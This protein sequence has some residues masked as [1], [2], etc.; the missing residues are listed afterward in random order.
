[1]PSAGR[2][3][4][5]W[6]GINLA[7][8]A[9]SDPTAAQFL[10]TFFNSGPGQ[11]FLDFFLR[12]RRIHHASPYGNRPVAKPDRT[13]LARGLFL[14]GFEVAQQVAFVGIIEVLFLMAPF[15]VAMVPVVV[16]IWQTP[17]VPAVD[18]QEL[19]LVPVG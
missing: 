3:L 15:A 4:T 6:V 9:S 16:R 10:V 14:V 5:S 11:A 8:A 13:P 19:G 17:T 1:V 12:F 7:A 18:N 2:W